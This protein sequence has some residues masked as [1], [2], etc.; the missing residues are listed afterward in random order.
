MDFLDSLSNGVSKVASNVGTGAINVGSNVGTSVQGNSEIAG[1][2]MQINTIEQ[3]LDASYATVG[4]KYVG[5]VLESGDMPGIDISDMMKLMQPKI[6]KL[7]ELQEKLAEA[8]KQVKN[9]DI[10]REKEKAEK[11]FRAEKEKLDRAKQM[12]LVDEDEY[13]QKLSVAQKKL[14]NFDKIRKL[15]TQLEMDLITRDEM[16]KQIEEL[17]KG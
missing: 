12:D 1:L 15:Q 2:K 13:N 6:D 10:L 7:K 17:M 11:E 8:E 16:N 5:Y 3:D 9:A 14:D 4:R